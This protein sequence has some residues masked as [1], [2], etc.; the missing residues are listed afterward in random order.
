VDFYLIQLPKEKIVLYS[1]GEE[2]YPLPPS[3]TDKGTPV[4]RL[5][6]KLEKEGTRFWLTVRKI[7]I[8][9]RETYYRLENRID[10]QERIIKRFNFARHCLFFCSVSAGEK[11][12]EEFLHRWLLYQRNKHAVWLLI[13]GVMALVALAFTPIL[14]PLPGP[15]F[16]LYY[17]LLRTLSHYRA[18]WAARRILQNSKAEFRTLDAL[19]SIEEIL[20]QPLAY[21]DEEQMEILSRNLKLEGLPAF[22]KRWA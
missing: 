1:E 17:P 6:G 16:F 3:E 2:L 11:M 22:V 21:R 14:V 19:D 5:L 7:I 20:R 18:Y 12:A 8:T 10:P 9:A 4:D 15:N 13:D